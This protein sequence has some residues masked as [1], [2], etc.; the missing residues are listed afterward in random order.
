MTGLPRLLLEVLGPV[1]VLVALGALVGAR[2]KLDHSALS[3]VAYWILGPAFAF[4]VLFDAQVEP[5]LVAKVTIV[6]LVGMLAAVTFAATASVVAGFSYPVGAAT[7][8]TAAYG[9]VGNAGIAISIFALGDQVLPIAVIALLAINVTGLSGGVA[10]ASAQTVSPWRAIFVALA[11]PMTAASGVA[12]I[13]NVFDVGVPVAVDRPVTLLADAMIPVMLL[14]LGIQLVRSQRSSF[15]ID[16]PISA[17]AK[18][19]IAPVAVWLA[20]KPLGLGG[21][22]AAVAVIQSA[23]PPAVLSALLA[24]EHNLEPERVTNAVVLITLA[25][26]VT[27]PIVLVL[28]TPT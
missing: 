24:T 3:R 12:L 20:T 16:L 21:D 11:A 14:T 22:A 15:S 5:E 18:L 17:L 6:C 19:V 10:L 7:V 9:N 28:V 2:L 4:D 13:L 1:A 27:L 25:S 23:M 8:M 26:I